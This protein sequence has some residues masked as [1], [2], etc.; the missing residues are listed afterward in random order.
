MKAY[1]RLDMTGAFASMDCAHLW[2]DKCPNAWNCLYAKYGG[3]PTVVFQV[4]VGPNKEIFS[5]SVGYPGAMND[6]MIS[7]QDPHTLNIL[8]HGEYRDV[9]YILFD[10][11][12]VPRIHKGACIIVGGGYSKIAGLIDPSKTAFSHMETVYAEWVE[13]VRKDVECLFGILKARFRFLKLPI[14]FHN[15]DTIRDAMRA[16]CILNN[17]FCGHNAMILINGRLTRIGKTLIRI[18]QMMNLKMNQM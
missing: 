7:Q 13:S 2:W 18:Y 16:C 10:D 4:I 15:I 8:Q 17:L 5:C 12:G 14:E 9:E 11:K 3:H 6:K 1:D